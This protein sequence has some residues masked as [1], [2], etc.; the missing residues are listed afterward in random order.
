LNN[1]EREKPP[2]ILP[3]ILSNIVVYYIIYQMQVNNFI[4]KVWKNLLDLAFPNN[5]NITYINKLSVEDFLCLTKPA[6]KPILT[7]YSF[8]FRL[9]EQI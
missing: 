7:K 2:P 8:Y 5:Y 4:R 9:Q 3:K 1:F 6:I